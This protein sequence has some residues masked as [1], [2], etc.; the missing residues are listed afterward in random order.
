VLVGDSFLKITLCTACETDAL[1][2]VSRAFLDLGM[3]F[4]T[5]CA[6]YKAVKIPVIPEGQFNSYFNKMQI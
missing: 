1:A 6:N 5:I 3:I 2:M 4:M